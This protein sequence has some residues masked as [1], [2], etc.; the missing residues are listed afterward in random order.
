M[1]TNELIIFEQLLESE[2]KKINFY[3]VVQFR[4]GH[5]TEVPHAVFTDKLKRN[6]PDINIIII[7][8]YD[9]FIIF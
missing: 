7:I 6:F 4:P 5:K 1:D 9:V 8:G 2:Q 3:Q